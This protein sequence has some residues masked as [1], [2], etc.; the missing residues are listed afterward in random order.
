MQVQPD[1]FSFYPQSYF[2]IEGPLRIPAKAADSLV[3]NALQAKQ[4]LEKI[5]YS[6]IT[7]LQQRKVAHGEHSPWLQIHSGVQYSNQDS[8]NGIEMILICGFLSSFFPF[9]LRV[10]LLYLSNDQCR[11]LLLLLIILEFFLSAVALK[12]TYGLHTN[13]IVDDFYV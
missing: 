8:V 13:F 10:W 11:L 3:T 6:L 7:L 12:Q 9:P 1:L 4:P 2:E 5:A